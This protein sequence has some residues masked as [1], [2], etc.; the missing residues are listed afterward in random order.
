MS[1]KRTKSAASNP[2]QYGVSGRA[3]MMAKMATMAA[4]LDGAITP[5]SVPI[6]NPPASLKKKKPKKTRSKHPPLPYY[7]SRCYTARRESHHDADYGILHN[8]PRVQSH[9]AEGAGASKTYP[10]HPLDD[11]QK[12]K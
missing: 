3:A 8:A 7:V 5:V 12:R 4:G 2:P 6:K 1:E 10:T 9:G 11:F